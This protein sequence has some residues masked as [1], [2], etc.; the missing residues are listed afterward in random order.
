MSVRHHLV[1]SLANESCDGVQTFCHQSK[2]LAIRETKYTHTFQNEN[3]NK[4]NSIF[5]IHRGKYA[6]SQFKVPGKSN[7][8]SLQCHMMLL[9][10]FMEACFRHRMKNKK[11]NCDFYSLNSVFFFSQLR[12]YFLQIIGP[13]F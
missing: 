11:G 7:H 8:F 13:F 2:A 5:S 12:L 1:L 10:Y 6:S 9:L 3:F 4:L